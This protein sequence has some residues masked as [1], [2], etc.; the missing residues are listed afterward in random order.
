MSFNGPLMAN[1]ARFYPPTLTGYTQSTWVIGAPG[2]HYDF[3]LSGTDLA[4]NTEALP[5]VAETGTV[6][7]D[8]ICASLDEWEADN[9]PQ[10]ASSMNIAQAQSHNLCNPETPDGLLDADWITF[11]VQAGQRYVIQ[12]I[13][14]APNAAIDISIFTG[15]GISLTLREEMTQNVWG[16]PSYID[17]IASKSEVLYIRVHH[18]DER[19]A[20]ST[21][22]YQ[23]YASR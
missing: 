4:G 17:W 3:R 7:P 10:L 20:G 22:T 21:V 1:L 6:I 5:S 2:H 13:P 14:T 19:V 11:S 23:M 16:L 15:D 12:A 18:S 9:T 8:N